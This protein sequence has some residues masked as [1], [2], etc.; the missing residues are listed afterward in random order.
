MTPQLPPKKKTVELGSTMTMSRQE[1]VLE[2]SSRP[3]LIK[4]GHKLEYLTIAYNSLEGLLPWRPDLSP[5]ILPRWV[6]IIFTGFN[7]K[8]AKK[9]CGF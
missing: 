7:F 3:E 6:G 9:V 2:N 4:Q 8:P 5:E 1:I